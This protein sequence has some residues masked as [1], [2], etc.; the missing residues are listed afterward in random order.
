[1]SRRISFIAAALFVAAFAPGA[2]AQWNVARFD[3]QPNRAYTTVGLDPAFIGSV[4]YGRVVPIMTHNFQLTTDI[5]VAT[6]RVD[7]RDFRAR[8][9]TQTS[10]VHWG[11]VHLSGNAAFVARGTENSIYRGF[12][13]G[14]DLGAAIGVY[15]SRW[16]AAVE[17]GKDKAII[18]HITNSGYYRSTYFPDAKDGWYLDAGGTI[19]HG[20]A[21]GITI[22]KT[23]LVGRFGWLKTEHYNNVLP[24]VYAMLGVGF[25]F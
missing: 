9:G 24:P 20:F 13:F 14:A 10:I 16:F 2:F 3:S 25:G 7:T 12:N 17:G 15:R 1:M 11:A 8:V 22:G 18:T 21:G 19:H 5:G 23:E 6:G 4:G